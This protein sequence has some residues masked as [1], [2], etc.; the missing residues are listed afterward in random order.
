MKNVR[1]YIKCYDHLKR[2]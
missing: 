2:F 1:H